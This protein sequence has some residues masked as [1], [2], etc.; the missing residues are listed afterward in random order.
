MV[1][2]TAPTL[3]SAQASVEGIASGLTG[4]ER[5]RLEHAFAFAQSVYE[6]KL[7]CTGE[8]PLEHA[9]GLARSIADLRL[10]TDA[11]VAGLLFAVPSYLPESGETLEA[12]FGE[13]VAA[14]VDGVA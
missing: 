4:P 10:D 13:H 11:R 7:L 12:E 3:Q 8:A 9:L 2:V 1:S 6:G 14:L 5:E